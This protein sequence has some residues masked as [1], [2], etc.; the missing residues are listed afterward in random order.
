MKT[1]IRYMV[2]SLH[3]DPL[4]ASL[5]NDEAVAIAVAKKKGDC[6]VYAVTVKPYLIAW[7]AETIAVDH[8]DFEQ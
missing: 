6:I 2:Y 8:G 5:Y 3:G 4:D 1:L 7:R